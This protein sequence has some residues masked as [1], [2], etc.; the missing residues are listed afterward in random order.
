MIDEPIVFI[1]EEDYTET[2]GFDVRMYNSNDDNPFVSAGTMLSTLYLLK[3]IFYH[4]KSDERQFVYRQKCLT[5][6]FWTYKFSMLQISHVNRICT[7]YS[8]IN[9]EVY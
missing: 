3:N 5:K 7:K 8:T 4:L 1:Q 2:L 6:I 9:G